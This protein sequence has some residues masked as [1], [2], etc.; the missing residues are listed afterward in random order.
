MTDRFT[1]AI[2]PTYNRPDVARDAIN[3]LHDQVHD[4]L[5]I[6]NGDK[7]AMPYDTE[8]AWNWWRILLH[9]E[10]PGNLS[11]I[12][13]LGIDF[14]SNWVKT[15]EP[16]DLVIVNDDAIVPPGWVAMVTDRMREMKAAAG[17]SGPS[18]HVLAEPGIVPYHHRMPGWAF[19]LAGEVGLRADEQF[20]WWC[21]DT[22]LDWEARKA[23]GMSMVTGPQVANR[24]ADQSTS[25]IRQM[26]AQADCTRFQAKWGQRPF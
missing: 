13:N 25:G 11:R 18:T 8:H 20:E 12:W 6:D 9:T 5:V 14:W 15:D 24:F 2:I 26:Q 16:W 23:G 22:D 1:A 19:C 17:C 21:G 3:S 7:I 10:Q 4:I